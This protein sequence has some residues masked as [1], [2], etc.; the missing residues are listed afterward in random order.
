MVKVVSVLQPWAS[1]IVTGNKKLETRSWNTKYRGTLYIH[2]SMKK[3]NIDKMDDNFTNQYLKLMLLGDGIQVPHFDQLPLGAIIGKV[4]LI[5]TIK[6]DK[7]T[8]N[9][10][11]DF[12]YGSL[13]EYTP[14]ELAFGDYSTNR[15]GWL[16]ANPVMF[17]KPIPAKGQLGIWNFDYKLIIS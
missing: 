2:A 3:P 15:F 9:R 6:S 1:L 4:D 14:Q 8:I 5:E 17:D 12:H 10:K 16:L 11:Q 7:D 13:F